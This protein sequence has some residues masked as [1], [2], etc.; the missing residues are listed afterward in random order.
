MYHRYIDFL[1]KCLSDSA[2]YEKPLSW[3]LQNCFTPSFI[4][5]V[6]HPYIMCFHHNLRF[7]YVE[8]PFS[9]KQFNTPYR[10]T[11]FNMHH[12]INNIL[13]QFLFSEFYTTTIK[14]HKKYNLIY[15]PATNLYGHADRHS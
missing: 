9:H 2:F 1:G 4:I 15:I 13:F 7:K 12:K 8:C 10:H 5:L 6:N 14:T 3:L 11:D